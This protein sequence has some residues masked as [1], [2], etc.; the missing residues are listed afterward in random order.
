MIEFEKADNYF[1][2]TMLQKED[3]NLDFDELPQHIFNQHSMMEFE[4][5][6]NDLELILLQREE[7]EDPFID[8]NELE[9]NIC[10]DYLKRIHEQ[11]EL[12]R[13]QEARD[14]VSVN[15]FNTQQTQNAIDKK[16]IELSIKF[17]NPHKVAIRERPKSASHHNQASE[18]VRSKKNVNIIAKYAKGQVIMQQHV[19]KEQMGKLVL[20]SQG[21]DFLETGPDEPSFIDYLEEQFYKKHYIIKNP[22]YY[23]EHE[24][25]ERSKSFLLPAIAELRQLEEGKEC[26]E[27]QYDSIFVLYECVLPWSGNTL[28]L[29]KLIGLIG[30]NSYKECYSCNIKSIY[31]SH[32]YYPITPPRGQGSKAILA[33]IQW[34]SPVEEDDVDVK[35]FRRLGAY[36][37][38]DASAIDHCIEVDNEQ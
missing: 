36:A 21:A 2:Q 34:K 3:R 11:E 9:H 10:K 31:F 27:I 8:F 23:I 22:L 28:A 15:N 17:K 13:A 24:R 12:I 14:N 25:T 1:E 19:Q 29:M 7:S 38:I 30:Q 4:E 26:P 33:Y 20:T 6:P 32:V 16:N 5:I 35:T 18:N 37:F